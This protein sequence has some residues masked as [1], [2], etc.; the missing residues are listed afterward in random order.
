MRRAGKMAHWV[1][2]FLHKYARLTP[3]PSIQIKARHSTAVALVI[4]VLDRKRWDF[5]WLTDY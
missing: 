5:L 1:K 3:T 2:C 4:P